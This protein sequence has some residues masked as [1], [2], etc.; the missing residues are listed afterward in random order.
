MMGTS[1]PSKSSSNNQRF[2]AR[3]RLTTCGQESKRGGGRREFVPGGR[4]PTS[5][6][7]S[8]RISQRSVIRSAAQR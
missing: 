4:Y 5:T 8:S 3:S 2:V 1:V 6:R 7:E